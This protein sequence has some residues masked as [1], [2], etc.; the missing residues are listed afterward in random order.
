MVGIVADKVVVEL[1]AKLDQYNARVISAEQQF[2]RSTKTMQGDAARTEASIRNSFDGIKK[3]L[4]ASTSVFAGAAGL[5][6]LQNLADGYTRYTNQLKVAGLEG[7]RLADT[8]NT[9]FGIAQKYGVQLESIGTLY[10]RAKQAGD[11]LGASQADLIKFTNGV[12]AAL[13]IQGGS[14]SETS[15]AL[16]Q[17]SQLLGTGTVRAEE[18]NSVNE[19]ARPILQAVAAG[20]DKYKGSVA[21]LRNDVIAGKVT[22][23][24]F[25]EGFLKGS[26]DLEAKASKANLTIGASFTVLN[27]AL[28]K[29]IGQ[30]DQSLSITARVSNGIATLADN[31]DTVVPALAGIAAGF[32]AVKLGSVAFDAASAATARAL[33][34]DKSLAAAILSGNASYV[35]RTGLVLAQAEATSAAT[36]A[37]VAALEAEVAARAEAVAATQAEVTAKQTLIVASGED[38]AAR[39]ALVVAVLAN[40]E[41]NAALITSETALA[42]AQGRAAVAAEAEAVAVVEATAAK[43]AGAVASALFAGTLSTLAAT[44]PVLAV[45]ALTAGIIYYA[46]T[47][48]GAGLDTKA[49]AAEGRELAAN[50]AAAK[51]AGDRAA[52]AIQSVGNQAASATAP[53]LSF[54][55]ATGEAAQRLYDLA[56]ARRTELLAGLESDAAKARQA[57]EDANARANDGRSP[58]GALNTLLAPFTRGGSASSRRAEDQATFIEA[59]RREQAANEAIDRVKRTPLRGFLTGSEQEGGRDV[60]GELAR[61]TRDLA[62]ARERG[63]KSEVD[64]QQANLFELQQYKKY[65]TQGLSPQAAADASGKDKA[66]FQAASR[67]AAGDKA[68]R[69]GRTAA[70]KAARRAAAIEKDNA[71]DAA[72]YAS[73][74]RRAN[75]GIASAKAELANDAAARA[76]I[77]RSRIEDE[78]LS[79]NEE[80]RQQFKQGQLGSGPEGQARL[81]ELQRLNDEKAALDTQVVDLHERQRIALEAADVAKSNVQN[82][83]DLLQAGLPLLDTNKERHAAAL[84]LLDLQ[85]QQE[86]IELEAVTVANGRTATEQKIAEARLAQLDKLQAADKAAVDR[87]YESPL[88]A[89]ARKLN[90]KPDQIREQVE[91]FVTDE[92]DHVRD[93]ITNA[94]TKALGIKDPLITSLINL[95]VEQLLIKPMADALAKANKSGGG[96]G[97]G[98]LG[99]IISFGT[100][101]FGGGGGGGGFPSGIGGIDSSSGDLIVTA[102]RASGGHV[103]AGQMYQVNESGVEG[104]RP[105]GSGQIIPLGQMRGARGGDTHLHQNIAI[106]NRGSINPDGYTDHIRQLVQNDTVRIVGAGMKAVNQ[107]VPHRLATYNRDGA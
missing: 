57:K 5:R 56:K 40:T 52:G 75:D 13:K 3:A 59:Q 49:F 41:A 105:S 22:S 16:L 9:L 83:R 42:A 72:R 27:N 95:L 87:Q 80:L 102:A 93:G 73:L 39:E 85:Y 7:S 14:A 19:G 10:S 76:D 63:I 103:N 32:G 79:R 53:M 104:F 62:I 91:G 20:I 31:L 65:R 8:Q 64:V 98:L 37:E 26:A 18:F 71:A 50:L 77:E 61:V 33:Q 25:F 84:R 101:L 70:E 100:S 29:Y 1:E 21:A 89:Y 51:A 44:L 38:A 78:R 67:G 46:T 90:K 43:R 30:T 28:G 60:T 47:A 97:G 82:E 94:I 58:S 2:T 34:I 6:A 106:D 96:G 99:S 55:N 86:R 12:A 4:L 92:L 48:K 11:S 35:S 15:G 81:L 17:L 45:A 74:D 107:N 36:V 69:A 54:A 88:D 23:Q 66:A 24:Q 68:A